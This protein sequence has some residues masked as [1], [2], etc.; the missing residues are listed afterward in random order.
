MPMYDT[1]SLMQ[2]G[3]PQTKKML[4]YGNAI[5]QNGKVITPNPKKFNLDYDSLFAIMQEQNMIETLKGVLRT[6]KDLNVSFL[7]VS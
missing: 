6:F 7:T 5:D 3:V 4:K 2:A 1:I